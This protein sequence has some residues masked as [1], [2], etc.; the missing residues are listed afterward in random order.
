[1]QLEQSF[2]CRS[3]APK[4]TL[5]ILLDQEVGRRPSLVKCGSSLLFSANNNFST[6]L[7]ITCKNSHLTSFALSCSS[8]LTR[9]RLKCDFSQ[10]LVSSKSPSDF[11]PIHLKNCP[12]VQACQ[13]SSALG[14]HQQRHQSRSASLHYS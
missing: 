14:D 5:F 12:Q 6:F 4:T 1:M 7:N 13:L 2:V 10:P 3:F 9:V 8:W 11:L